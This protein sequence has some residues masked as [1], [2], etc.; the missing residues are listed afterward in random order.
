[1]KQELSTAKICEHTLLY[2]TSVVDRHLCHMAAEFGV[3]VRI[4]ASFSILLVTSATSKTLY[5]T[6]YC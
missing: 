6:F 5:A 2:E 3:F 4:T 1:M